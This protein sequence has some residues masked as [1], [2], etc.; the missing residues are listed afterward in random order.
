MKKIGSAKILGLF[1]CFER[2]SEMERRFDSLLCRR[3]T[4][5]DSIFPL[6]SSASSISRL[7]FVSL[8]ACL[9]GVCVGR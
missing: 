1:H 6:Y 7:F 9:S 5:S 8:C 2:A 3:V 4:F